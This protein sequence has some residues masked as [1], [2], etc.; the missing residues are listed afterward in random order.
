[1]ERYLVKPGTKVDLSTIDTRETS[2]FSDTS[3]HGHTDELDR[4]RDELKRQQHLLYSA[5][6]K[7]VLV[8]IQA[9]D[10][11]GKDG[12]VRHFFSYLDPQ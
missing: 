12:T 1:M 6:T 3:K 9:M 8:V 2:L 4:L 7:K 5:Q 10:T 11:G